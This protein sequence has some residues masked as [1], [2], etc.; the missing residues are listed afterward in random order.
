[1]GV[2]VRGHSAVSEDSGGRA[3][4]DS[5]SDSNKKMGKWSKANK[6]DIG[7]K[8]THPAAARRAAQT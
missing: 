1:M 5:S 6:N 7:R 3:L 2:I 8:S 4:T